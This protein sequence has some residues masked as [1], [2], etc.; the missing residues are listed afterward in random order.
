MIRLL[1][2]STCLASV[3]AAQQPPAGFERVDHDIEIGV[4]PGLLRYDRESFSVRPA[5]SV[6]LTLVN[7][8]AMQH[9]LLVCRPGEDVTRRV[10]AAAAALGARASSVDFVPDLPDVLFHT[11][12]VL[13]GERDTIRFRAPET[14]GDYPYVCTLPGHMFTMRGVMHVGEPRDERPLRDLRY[15]VFEGRWSNLPDFA[16]LS[17][18]AT[19]DLEDGVIELEVTQRDTDYAAVFEGVLA[20][21]NAGAHVFFLNSD[22]GSRLSID[23]RVVAEY[24]GVHPASA[25]QRV[26]IELA[27][28]PHALAVEYFQAGGGQELYL[29]YAGPDGQRRLL[30]G[31]Q[32]ASEPRGI[33]IAVHHA[34]VVM[35]VYIEDAAP[36][37]I[38]VGLLDGINY[39]FDAE[40]CSVQFGWVGAFLDVGPDRQG[41]GGR[42]CKTLGPRF[43]V[44]DVGF[45]L[46]TASGQLRPVRLRGYRTDATP[47]LTLDWGGVEVTWTVKAAPDG[48]GL[49]YEFELGAVTSD[50]QFVVAADGL[51]LEASAGTWR[52]GCLTVPAAA[53][54]SFNVTLRSMVSDK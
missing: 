18:V 28:G 26:E 12:A 4:L 27:A 47:S 42:P 32:A 48:V 25:E 37:S 49:R 17:P 40:R 36:R 51:R 43:P 24:D 22:D 35:R 29:A 45:P 9:N 20:T 30:T 7:N 39:C 50:V 21:P 1:F 6:R 31:A 44:G 8:D 19:G 52:G 46:R 2:A 38:A 13:P 23:G 15:R 14:A 5:S 54:R 33:P 16:T 41:R 11:R 10:G 53:A 3:L 34:P